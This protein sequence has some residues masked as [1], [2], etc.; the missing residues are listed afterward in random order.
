MQCL[1]ISVSHHDTPCTTLPKEKGTALQA[2]TFPIPVLNTDT[3][4]K[5]VTQPAGAGEESPVARHVQRV[6]PQL[7]AA[8]ASM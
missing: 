8:T 2:G 7:E 5:K 3:M 4:D 1:H 6:K